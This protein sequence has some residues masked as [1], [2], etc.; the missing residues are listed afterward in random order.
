MRADGSTFQTGSSTPITLRSNILLWL[1]V[2]CFIPRDYIRS[3][4]KWFTSGVTPRE[5][6]NLFNCKNMKRII[7]QKSCFQPSISN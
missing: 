1:R 2:L 7:S 6:L 3:S 4:V 5:L